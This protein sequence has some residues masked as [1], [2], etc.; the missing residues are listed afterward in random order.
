MPWQDRRTKSCEAE[1]FFEQPHEA[2]GLCNFKEAYY[3]EMP[4]PVDLGQGF[5]HFATQ[6]QTSV[7]IDCGDGD[8]TVKHL[9]GNGILSLD[10]GCHA[11][12]GTHEPLVN[13]DSPKNISSNI[14]VPQ[15]QRL[16]FDNI[17]NAKLKYIEEELQDIKIEELNNNDILEEEQ[18]LKMIEDRLQKLR[19]SIENQASANL[20]KTKSKAKD[21]AKQLVLQQEI[22]DQRQTIIT[23][24]IFVIVVMVLALAY[25][26]FI[27][28]LIYRRQK[29]SLEANDENN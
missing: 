21:N 23:V 12:V 17:R 6:T 20:N 13:L 4:K 9:S 2:L 11:R 16:K 22:I 19:G 18:E 25:L 14:I 1:V 27:V 10:M 24:L 26:A 28:H 29:A 8:I 15:Y 7:S 5:Y 3:S